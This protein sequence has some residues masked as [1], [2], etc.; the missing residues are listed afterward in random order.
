MKEKFE[1]FLNDRGLLSAFWR[2]AN[3][4]YGIANG[5][6]EKTSV[7]GYIVAVG[8]DGNFLTIAFK[9]NDTPEGYEFWKKVADEWSY[10]LKESK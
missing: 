9:W 10:E 4:H 7:L 8:T 1:K 3:S 5:R 2:N 6:P